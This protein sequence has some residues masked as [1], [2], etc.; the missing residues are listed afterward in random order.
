MDASGSR[1]ELSY[2]VFESEVSRDTD[3][4][5]TSMTDSNGLCDMGNCLSKHVQ[6]AWQWHNI[7]NHP[8][9]P[10]VDA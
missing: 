1:Y 8:Q 9:F 3:V 7:K 5:C 4:L 2:Y 10:R 6:E